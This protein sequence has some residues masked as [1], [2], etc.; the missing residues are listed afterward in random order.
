MCFY[1]LRPRSHFSVFIRPVADR[2]G[3]STTWN[4][5]TCPVLAVRSNDQGHCDQAVVHAQCSAMDHN[6]VTALF[7]L[8]RRRKRRRNRLHCV[9]PVIKKKRKDSLPFTHYLV[10]YEMTQTR[11]LNYFR[12]SVSPFDEMHRRL[13]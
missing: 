9:H 8:D 4:F 11:F 12:M 1:S 5:I 6:S 7:L 3:E 2:T 13:K 10:I